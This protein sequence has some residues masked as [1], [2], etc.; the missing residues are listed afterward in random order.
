MSK[1]AEQSPRRRRDV[2]FW[3]VAVCW[4]LAPVIGVGMLYQYLSTKT[5]VATQE[6]WA[7]A[8]S[9]EETRAQAVGLALEWSDGAELPAPAWSGTIVR[10]YVQP[11]GV[12]KSGD[13][14]VDVDGVK[15]IAAFM[16]VPL[17][18]ALGPGST[19]EDVKALLD[20]LRTRG[21]DVPD[22]DRLS[23]DTWLQVSSFAKSI[24]VDTTQGLPSFDPGWLVFI[25]AA[26][27][28]V[29]EVHV[30]A[31]RPAPA[32]GEPIATGTD[33]LVSAHI[34]TP[35][36]IAEVTEDNPIA[37]EVIASS[38]VAVPEDAVVLVGQNELAV[39]EARTAIDPAAL[40]RVAAGVTQGALTSSARVVTPQP[41]AIV[42]PA[43][44]VLTGTDGTCVVVRDGG[45]R[46]V[47]VAETIESVDGTSLIA[48]EV[49]AGESVLVNPTATGATCA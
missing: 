44:A 43:A 15:R 49:K 18:R 35:E 8:L 26:E 4:I 47:V 11:G 9:A 30:K 22:S 27:L 17:Y 12:L 41:A 36:A 31:G 46:R 45:K 23:W 42:V 32:S 40:P 39:D 6:V 7:P 37:P 33:Q 2:A 19:G 10:V 29:S 13:T 1:S 14:V 5:V 38:A 3:V 48:A 28:T 20:F 34:V 16:N 24:G 21:I 25:P